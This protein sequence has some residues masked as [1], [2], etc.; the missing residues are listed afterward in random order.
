LGQR[1]D[2]VVASS[3]PLFL[4]T[5]FLSCFKG[6]I[7]GAPDIIV[8]VLSPSNWLTDRR[9]KFRVYAKAG[10]HEYWIINTAARTVE[11]FFLRDSQYELIGKYG[12]GETVRSEVLPG[13]EVKV[14][15]ICPAQN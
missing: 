1:G 8:E 6:R 10:V 2:A 3:T 12:V 7:E 14:E 4:N 11:L 9:D 5:D 13:F 15:K